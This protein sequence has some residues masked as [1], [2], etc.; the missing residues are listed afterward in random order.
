MLKRVDLPTLWKLLSELCSWHSQGNMARVNSIRRQI[1]LYE[2]GLPSRDR[3]PP[4]PL[5]R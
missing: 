4:V 2:A 1:E 5:A 3:S